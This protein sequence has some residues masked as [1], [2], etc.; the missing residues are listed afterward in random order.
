M[1]NN[2]SLMPELA[3]R[4]LARVWHPCTSMARA[5]QRPPLP[6]ARGEGPW[7]FDSEGRR[8]FDAISSWWVNLF[9][10]SDEGLRAAITA[11]LNTLPHAM[12]AGCTHEPVVRLAERLCARTGGALAHAS[13]G[14]DGASAV[15]IALKQSFHAWRNQGRAGKRGFVALRG[16]YHGETLG[17]LSV[18]DVAIFRDAYDPL[19]M[20]SRLVDAPDSRL[21]NQ[22]QALAALAALLASEA[23]Q[24]AAVLIEP[25]VQ[26]AA[27]MVMHS[28][29]YLRE[30]RRLCTAHGVHLI[31][32]E[33]AV[34]CGRTGRF[35]AWSHTEPAGPADWPDFLLLSKGITGGTLPL[36][37]VLGS[38]A[39]F[40]AFWSDDPTRAFLHSHSYTGNPLACAAAN[41]VLDRFDA[42]QEARCAEQAAWLAQAFAPLAQDPRVAHLRQRGTIL[43]FDL[44]GA[45]ADVAERFHLA[46]RAHG[47]LIRPIGRTV[48]LMPPYL[49]DPPTAAWLAE[50][51]T[52][53][54]NDVV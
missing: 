43:A 6:L 15:E 19:L 31:A 20:R 14:S 51:V 36:S 28:P 33:I 5:A 41:A 17:A 29:D 26:G 22:D 24:L 39:V 54:L 16:G 10:H 25:L 46:G 47:L 30:L 38:E 12:L 2:G 32:D 35:F 34:G 53:T 7:L 44:P 40:Q 45:A 18:T 3:A 50:A 9:G 49:V 37:V 8:Y 42:G 48:Y 1:T 27:G 11:Q 21:G 13:F 4:S 23:D 52:D